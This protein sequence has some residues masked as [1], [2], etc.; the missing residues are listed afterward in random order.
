MTVRQIQH[1]LAFLGYYEQEVDGVWGSASA[2]AARAFQRDAG[3]G[4]DGI[5]G[6]E[7]QEALRRAVGEGKAQ[8]DFWNGIRYFTQSE[9]ACKCG[10]GLDN[11]NQEL[12]MICDQV[13]ADLGVFQITSGLRCP[14]HNARQP[15]AAANSRHVYGKAVDFSIRGKT[16][17]QVLAYVKAIPKIAYCYAID[18]THV[19]MDIA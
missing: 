3:I 17:D 6:R 2:E 10:C 9:F 15:G 8:D 16:A 14:A 13:R 18:G 5:P 19:H 12:V 4:V 11:V 1:L 7:T